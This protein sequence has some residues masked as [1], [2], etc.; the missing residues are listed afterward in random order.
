[1]CV[2]PL[3]LSTTKSIGWENYCKVPNNSKERYAHIFKIVCYTQHGNIW[4]IWETC[5]TMSF[6][7]HI[8]FENFHNICNCLC[9]VCCEN[10]FQNWERS[11]SVRIIHDT[12]QYSLLDHNSSKTKEKIKTINWCVCVCVCVILNVLM[13]WGM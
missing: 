1:L 12:L 6:I 10:Y 7:V 9:F 3:H 2:T 5:Q 8:Y 11:V 13:G 4:L